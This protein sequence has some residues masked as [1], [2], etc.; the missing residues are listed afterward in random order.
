MLEKLTQQ[1]FPLP[2]FFSFFSFLWQKNEV[3]TLARELNR[4]VRAAHAHLTGLRSGRVIRT[5][6]SFLSERMNGWRASL[7][8]NLCGKTFRFSSEKC[9]PP[10]AARPPFILLPFIPPQ[11]LPGPH[12]TVRRRR[13]RL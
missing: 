4:V 1:D 2:P 7:L 10:T 11:L 6:E 13:R 3:Q 5:L 8:W 12:R 9:P